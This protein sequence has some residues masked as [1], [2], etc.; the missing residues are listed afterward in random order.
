MKKARI[1]KYY[2]SDSINKIL[3]FS[4]SLFIFTLF[5]LSLGIDGCLAGVGYLPGSTQ[6]ICQLTGD[7]DKDIN[8]N[9]PTI[10]LTDTRYGVV[11]TDLGSSFKHDGKIY[12]LFGDT[13]PSTIIPRPEA[14]DSIAYTEETYPN[15]CLN[16]TFNTGIDGKFDPPTVLFPGFDQGGCSVPVEGLSYNGDMYVYFIT[17]DLCDDH[18]GECYLAKSLNDGHTFLLLYKLSVDY[19]FLKVQ[20]EVVENSDDIQYNGIRQLLPTNV[21]NQPVLFIWGSGKHREGNPYLAYMPLEDIENK[22]EIRYYTGTDASGIPQ[23]STSGSEAVPLFTHPCVGDPSVSWN[24]FLKKWLMLYTCS[25]PRGVNFRVADYPWGTWSETQ[26]LFDANEDNGLCYFMHKYD[27]PDAG[28]GCD[29]NYDCLQEDKNGNRC[30]RGGG[31]YGPYVISDFSEGLEG[32]YTT[33]YFTLS[34]W[35]PYQVMLMKSTLVVDCSITVTSP[36]SGEDC[37]MYNTKTIMWTSSG[38]GNYVKIELGLPTGCGLSWSTITS[39]TSNDGSYNWSVPGPARNNCK[40]KICSLDHPDCCGE[41][42]SFDMVL[43]T[44]TV[45]SPSSGVNWEIGSSKSIRWS[46]LG[47]NGNVSIQLGRPSGCGYIWSTITSSTSNDGSYDWEV[48]GPAQDNCKIRITSIAHTDVYG[49][50]GLFDI[51]TVACGCTSGSI[52]QGF[53]SDMVM[54]AR[55]PQ[56]YYYEAS[57]ACAEGWHVCSPYEYGDNGGASI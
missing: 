6:K 55:V 49:E 43:P 12:F 32:I 27:C 50:S 8:F 46:S 28:S 37:L 24:P 9:Q 44:I 47:V 5:N 4:T 40:I 34:T 14:A 16:L 57:Q 18:L 30:C 22:S 11:G 31:A 52:R 41:S 42:P 17:G 51:I 38:A 25:D 48:Q 19:K 1:R 13:Y 7:F 2:P 36:S 53:S 56:M 35:N 21:Q 54:C 39:S 23:W 33:I 26:V 45:S 29:Q 10:N 20:V 3:L 15:N